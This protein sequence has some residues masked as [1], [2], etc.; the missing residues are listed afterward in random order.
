M[1]ITF[2]KSLGTIT[3][4]IWLILTG[5]ITLVPAIHFA[6]LSV[7]MAILAIL[8]GVLILAGK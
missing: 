6:G 1:T 8:S 4:A 5:L 7:V 2:S 3:L